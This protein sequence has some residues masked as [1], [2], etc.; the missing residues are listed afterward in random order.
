MRK[1]H[2]LLFSAFTAA[3]LVMSSGVAMGTAHAAPNLHWSATW[4]ASPQQVWTADFLFPT[5]ISATLHDQTIRQVARISLGGDRVRLVF[6]NQYGKQPIKLGKV[7]IAEAATNSEIRPDSLRTV[8]FG[9]KES[10]I[11]PVGSSWLSDP[12]DLP[13]SSLAQVAVSIYL[14]DSTP[15]NTFHWDARQTAWI[16]A[17]NQ[18]A[19][20]TFNHQSLQAQTTTTRTLLSGLQVENPQASPVVAVIGDSI[21]DGATASL[22]KNTCWPDFL[23]ARL[24]PHGVAVINA[25]ISGARLLSDGMGSN[26]LARLNRDI[27]VQPGISSLIVALGINDI[28]WPGTAFA[29]NAKRPTLDDLTAAYHQLVEQAHSRGI[30]VIGTTITPFQDAL[31]DTPLANYYSPEKDQL[32]QQVNNW[33][34]HS[35]VFDAVIDFDKTLADRQHPARIAP[36]FDS[37]DHLHP[38]DTGN[39][40]MANAVDLNLLL[41]QP[42]ASFK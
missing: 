36:A 20:T 18:T 12:V 22:D 17:G 34:R 28:A 2:Q 8:T 7:T 32:R 41:A 40:A 6:S 23:A 10:T 19:T 15:V 5:N 31:P 1:L 4:Q 37:G 30:R 14:P 21:T 39:Q 26:A 33:I 11:I 25:G 9:G 29:P 24:A 38:G 3:S 35:R 27:L 42:S 16:I 13:V